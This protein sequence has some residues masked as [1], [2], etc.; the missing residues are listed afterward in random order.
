MS[1]ELPLR[2][3]GHSSMTLRVLIVDDEAVARRRIKRYLSADAS[4]NVV[5]ECS[6]GAAAVNAIATLSP[7]LVFLDVQMPELN[8]FGVLEALAPSAL[9]LVVFVTAFDRYALRAFDL[10]AIDYLLKPFTKERFT[11]AL[12][13]A[14]GPCRRARA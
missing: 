14:K 1:L 4:V 12:D 2:L 13:R 7:E 5:G 10:H 11:A 9:P 6:D 3:D 8:G